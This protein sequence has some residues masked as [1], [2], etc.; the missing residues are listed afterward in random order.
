MG[1]GGGR[2][3][4]NQ[5]GEGP[6]CLLPSWS[7]SYTHN[8][9]NAKHTVTTPQNTVV[10]IACLTGTMELSVAK[11]PPTC[12]MYR[13][14]PL[15]HAPTNMYYTCTTH[16]QSICTCI[17]HHS[18]LQILYY[19]RWLIITQ[20]YYSI[21]C[22]CTLY[23]SSHHHQRS[24]AEEQA[25]HTCPESKQPQDSA[26]HSCSWVRIEHFQHVTNCMLW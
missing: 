2:E 12:N 14:I 19:T 26:T 15:R 3:K 9:T 17:Y 22:T 8:H 18:R 4:K 21:Y 10:T 7:N 13:T 23:N 20:Y 11:Q 16:I 24:P 1:G 6:L 25:G 5:Q